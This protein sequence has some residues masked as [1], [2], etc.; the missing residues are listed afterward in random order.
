VEDTG[1]DR[2]KVVRAL[3]AEALCRPVVTDAARRRLR[4]DE[5]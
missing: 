3:L 2:S 4:E 5:L 1:R